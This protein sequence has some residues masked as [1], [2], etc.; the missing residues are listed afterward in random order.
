MEFRRGIRDRD[1]A[2]WESLHALYGRAIQRIVR[3]MVSDRHPDPENV[4]A[5]VWY[6]AVKGAHTYDVTRWPYPWLARI[7]VNTCLN[8]LRRPTRKWS[9]DLP[10]R[11]RHIALLRTLFHAESRGALYD[12]IRRLPR[13]EQEVVTLR[14]L[15]QIPMKEI[16]R[17][18]GV[19]QNSVCKT[20][21]RALGRLRRGSD[22]ETLATWMEVLD[23][24]S[25][26]T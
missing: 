11:P 3:Q 6:R 2:A 4:L 16:G 1:P 13:R 8:E 23:E 7:C 20:A 15:C 12:S 21:V 10:E 5:E 25:D 17:L 14:F 9:S 22:A 26:R 24:E 19:R 18:L